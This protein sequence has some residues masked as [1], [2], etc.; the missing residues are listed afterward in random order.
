MQRGDREM[1]HPQRVKLKKR[2][3]GVLEMKTY[4]IKLNCGMSSIHYFGQNKLV[5]V[6]DD[7]VGS[8]SY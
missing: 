4:G 5:C 2:I 3:D 6:M 7:Q 8:F 1:I